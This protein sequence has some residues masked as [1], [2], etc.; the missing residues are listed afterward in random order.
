MESK[1]GEEKAVEPPNTGEQEEFLEIDY[2]SWSFLQDAAVREKLLSM[3]EKEDIV[4]MTEEKQ[5]RRE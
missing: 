1:N 5:M 2:D 3:A 4:K